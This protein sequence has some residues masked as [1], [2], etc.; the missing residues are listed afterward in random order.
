[1]SETI[2]RRG[3]SLQNSGS[4]SVETGNTTGNNYRVETHISGTSRATLNDGSSN[5]MITGTKSGVVMN[6]EFSEV[7]GGQNQFV[8]GSKVT[9]VQGDVYFKFGNLSPTPYAREK[10]VLKEIDSY[11]SLFEVKRTD[12][13]G[14]FNSSE[15]SK[16]GQGEPCRA[17]S[18]NVER[19]T[20]DNEGGNSLSDQLG[21]LPEIDLSSIGFPGFDLFNTALSS[22][23]VI[24][25]QYP[26]TNDCK[27]CGGTGFSP[28]SQNGEFEPDE[29]KEQIGKMYEQSASTLAS[30]EQDMGEGGSFVTEVAKNM[31]I[32]IG[33]VFNDLNSVRTDPQG[34]LIQSGFDIDKK[35]MYPTEEASPL[36]EPKHVDD[37]SGGTLTVLANNKAAFIV[38]AGGL[39]IQSAG[40]NEI[41]GSITNITG[42]QVNISS[43]NEVNLGGSRLNITSKA[44]SLKPSGGQLVV[45]SNLAVKSNLMVQGGAMISGPLFCNG[46]SGPLS[47][48]LTEELLESY[49]TTNDKI[50][51]IIGYW[52]QNTTWEVEVAE[53]STNICVY[54]QDGDANLGKMKSGGRFKIKPVTDIEIKSIGASGKPD[55]QSVRIYPHSHVFRNINLNLDGNSEN[56]N[57]MAKSLVE[58]TPMAP[59]PIKH[60]LTGSDKDKE[61]SFNKKSDYNT[62]NSATTDSG[63]TRKRTV[64]ADFRDV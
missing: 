59:P 57:E 23:P 58:N 3:G 44:L 5:E 48:Q 25:K 27:E 37:L 14:V 12:G 56:I 51:K 43:S 39:K 34:K 60:G 2:V 54:A 53:D 64:Y 31:V 46:I 19:D 36:I 26:K 40:I 29:R 4:V 45:D 30:A 13:G 38:G 7:R 55:S 17:C 21:N 22:F 28:S 41:S 9:S 35:G 8:G 18:Q 63:S 10:T 15:Q 20:Y 32:S 47:Y 16:S 1:M 50:S 62:N 33:T 52:V 61:T 49:A 11:K 24:K 42:E 6:D